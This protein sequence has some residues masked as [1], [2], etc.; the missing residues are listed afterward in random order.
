MRNCF[1][2]YSLF[3]PLILQPDRYLLL[4]YENI[5]FLSLAK[6]LNPRTCIPLCVI[7]SESQS[8]ESNFCRVKLQCNETEQKRKYSPKANVQRDLRRSPQCLLS[9]G[10]ISYASHTACFQMLLCASRHVINRSQIPSS[11]VLCTNSSGFASLHVVPLRKTSTTP[12]PRSFD[13][14]K[15]DG[16]GLRSG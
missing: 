7:L 10:C 12:L 14:L 8:D 3:F 15:D 2:H 13:T 9:L 11:S 1:S 16:Q 5:I 4:L 6:A